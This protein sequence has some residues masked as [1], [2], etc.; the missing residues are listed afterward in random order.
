MTI[1]FCI[2]LKKHPNES[3][4]IKDE[5]LA[6]THLFHRPRH[7]KLLQEACCSSKQCHKP[8]L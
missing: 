7:I 2:Y 3:I 4:E 5:I 8:N 6:L 1:I